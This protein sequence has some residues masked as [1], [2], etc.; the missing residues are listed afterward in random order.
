[1]KP[2]V[3]DLI[4]IIQQDQH[5][6][7]QANAQSGY[8]DNAVDLVSAK[9]PDSDL[10]IVINHLAYL[11]MLIIRFVKRLPDLIRLLLLPVN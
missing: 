11:Y 1:M 8:I 6:A 4:F 5:T 9:V 10:D 7:G 3:T 2:V